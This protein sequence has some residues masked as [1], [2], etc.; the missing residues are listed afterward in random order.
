[1]GKNALYIQIYQ[2]IKNKID[3]KEYPDGYRL[4]TEQEMISTYDVS[5]ITIKKA[6]NALAAEKLIHKIQGNGTFVGAPPKSQET[7]SSENKGLI[8]VVVPGL[9]VYFGSSFLE[10]VINEART[11]GYSVVVGLSNDSQENES[12][13][14]DSLI[15]NGVEGLIIQPVFSRMYNTEV[16][17][18]VLDGH[19]VVFFDR[20]IEGVSVSYVGSKNVES[21]KNAMSYLFELGHSNVAFLSPSAYTSSI[22]EREKGYI[23]AYSA[24]KHILESSHELMDLDSALPSSRLKREDDIIKIK[25]LLSTHPEITAVMC[26]D[27]YIAT[28]AKQAAFELGLSV[29]NQLSIVS[30]NAP[31]DGIYTSIVENQK[32]LAQA[33]VRALL[34]CISQGGGSAIEMIDTELHIGS[35]TAKLDM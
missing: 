9:G 4:P 13:V 18:R 8:G 15:G 30:F 24:S 22:K 31:D 6:M 16:I 3:S 29:P 21:V 7:D 19:P 5:R 10:V 2:E 35:S 26:M 28:M 27:H 25:R 23:L 1:M 11:Q 20:Y 32:A 33:A 12:Q 17:R 34:G 14:I